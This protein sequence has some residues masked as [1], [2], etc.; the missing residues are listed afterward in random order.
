VVLPLSDNEPGDNNK[1][2][3]GN[4]PGDDTLSSRHQN[5]DDESEPEEAEITPEKE[6]GV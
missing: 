6:L 2:G 5:A 3:D 1:L 4:K